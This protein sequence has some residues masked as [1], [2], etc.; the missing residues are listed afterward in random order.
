M[1]TLRQITNIFSRHVFLLKS[2]RGNLCRIW[3]SDFR[4]PKFLLPR[5]SPHLSSFK[6]TRVFTR[7]MSH[8]FYVMLFFLRKENQVCLHVLFV[9]FH[10]LCLT[11]LCPMSSGVISLCFTF[12]GHSFF[13]RGKENEEDKAPGFEYMERQ[14]RLEIFYKVPLPLIHAPN[15]FM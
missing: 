15:C 14:F 4:T 13:F 6:K 2:Y 11:Y 9:L 12:L 3:V 8:I 7:Q 1:P 5:I 10:V